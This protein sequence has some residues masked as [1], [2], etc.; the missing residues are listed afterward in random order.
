MTLLVF[1]PASSPAE[2]QEVSDYIFKKWFSLSLTTKGLEIRGSKPF[3]GKRVV[4]EE[5]KTFFINSSTIAIKVPFVLH[6]G[7]HIAENLQEK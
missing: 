6:K 4:S 7:K 1:L 2:K 5:P 3:F